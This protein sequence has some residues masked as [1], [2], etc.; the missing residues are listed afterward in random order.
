MHFAF[1]SLALAAVVFLAGHPGGAAP[2]LDAAPAVQSSGAGG[3][4]GHAVWAGGA[5]PAV[6]FT[7]VDADIAV[8]VGVE[9]DGDKGVDTAASI[10]N[11]A[12]TVAD[13]IAANDNDTKTGHTT[14]VA[15]AVAGPPSPPTLN[16]TDLS[17]KDSTN[18]S[19]AT[20]S[21]VPNCGVYIIHGG[22]SFDLNANPQCASAEQFERIMEV[23]NDA[24]GICMLFEWENCVGRMTWS[25]KT[26]K[27][28]TV[29]VPDS[30]SWFC[31]A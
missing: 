8:A 25:G 9:A 2:V 17:N 10:K 24:C 30:R 18:V 27:G 4:V 15:V 6:S 11:I 26:E 19:N 31:I 22:F 13:T 12:D 20:T 5:A 3:G 23:R 29:A 21:A 7:G 1:P 14:T 28:K 16:T